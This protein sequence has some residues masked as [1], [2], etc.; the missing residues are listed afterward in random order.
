MRLIFRRQFLYNFD[1]LFVGRRAIFAEDIVMPDVRLRRIRLGTPGKNCLRLAIHKSP[2]YRTDF[3]ALV[4][5]I[6]H[7]ARSIDEIAKEYMLPLAYNL[8]LVFNAAHT[9]H[10]RNRRNTIQGD[11]RSDQVIGQFKLLHTE[12][13]PDH[14]SARKREKFLKSGQGREFLS[15]LY[16]ATEPA[17]GG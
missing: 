14:L 6:R 11:T 7:K 2:V 3:S 5:S 4:A 16:P 9:K 17:S 8:F 10:I 12:E 15:S 1:F 13:F